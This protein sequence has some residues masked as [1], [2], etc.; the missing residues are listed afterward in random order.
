[1]KFD[2]LDYNYETKADGYK[3]TT[4]K[5]RS[6]DDAAGVSTTKADIEDQSAD[7][8]SYDAIGNLTSDNQEEIAKIEMDGIGQG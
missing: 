1:M 4:N 8:Y 5:L 7:N 2:E 6:L 3:H